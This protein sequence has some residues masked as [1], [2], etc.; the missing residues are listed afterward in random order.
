MNSVYVVIECK[1]H[2]YIEKGINIFIYTLL[3]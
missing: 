1:T 2:V 3:F